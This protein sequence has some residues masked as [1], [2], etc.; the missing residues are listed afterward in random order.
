MV[1]GTRSFEFPK[2][3]C[4]NCGKK[5]FTISHSIILENSVDPDQMASLELRQLI[6]IYN[7]FFLI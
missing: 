3:I 7:N 1:A 2:H 4:Y 5:I 6:W